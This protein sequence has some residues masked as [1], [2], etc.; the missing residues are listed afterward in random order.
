MEQ[1]KERKRIQQFTERRK[2]LQ[3][4]LKR[5]S[6]Q[7]VRQVANEFLEQFVGVYGNFAFGNMSITY[8][9][10]TSRLQADYG[11]L[12]SI[13]LFHIGDD[14]FVG[15]PSSLVWFFP[16][17]DMTFIRR[18]EDNAVVSVTVPSLLEA[19]P[20]VFVRGLTMDQAPKPPTC[21]C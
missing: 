8:N 10:D 20:P 1:R 6:N 18:S 21:D 19:D 16:P 9:N 13:D 11:D 7:H 4:L 3:T 15:Q 17:A 12:L 14:W 2:Y 5:A